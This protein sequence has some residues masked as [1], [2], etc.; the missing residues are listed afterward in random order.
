MP[1]NPN[2][3]Y[4]KLSIVMNALADVSMKNAHHTC[5]LSKSH[6]EM[7]LSLGQS[8]RERSCLRHVITKASGIS[9]TRARKM[10]GFEALTVKM[11]QVDEAIKATQD[12]RE[13][14]DELA[15]IEDKMLASLGIEDSSESDGYDSNSSSDSSLCSL[16][17]ASS[18]VCSHGV[19]VL[20]A[21]QYNWF[22]LLHYLEEAEV[23]DNQVKLCSQW[24]FSHLQNNDELSPSKM[25]LLLQSKEAW[26]AVENDSIEQRRIE[27]AVN[28][29]IVTDSESDDPSQYIGLTG[30]SSACGQE[31][32][33]KRRKAIR[34][35]AK[36]L[37]SKTVAEQRLLC[38]R[39]L[40]QVSRIE[41]ECPNI[42]RV[43]EDF[44][45]EGNI[46]ADAW[47]RTGSMVMLNFQRKSLTNEF[48]STSKTCIIGTFH[49]EVWLSVV[50]PETEGVDQ[51]SA[52][53][54][55][56]R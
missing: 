54:V 7:L 17:E 35:R 44:V 10:Y 1:H 30:P 45:Q 50:L 29:D 34:R 14:I 32:I 19:T 55:L 43:V 23:D 40:P 31:L 13:A 15:S 5:T 46:G 38:R 20:K 21:N 28:G 49:M 42:G 24:I 39:V 36:K 27:R 33:I 37:H 11:K 8:E 52:T 9:A 48:A 2:T 18:E 16:Q 22:A 41:R 6:V 4:T 47:R 25:A 53:K 3:N 12:I 26:E 56:H 51:L